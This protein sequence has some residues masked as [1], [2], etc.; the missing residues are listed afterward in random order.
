MYVSGC[1]YGSW[2]V[3]FVWRHESNG[4]YVATSLESETAFCVNFKY[5]LRKSIY[6]ST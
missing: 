3:S 1:D 5:I 6:Q 4:E 2:I